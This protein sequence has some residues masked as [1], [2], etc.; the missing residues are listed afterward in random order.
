MEP[1]SIFVGIELQHAWRLF[2][3]AALDSN[4]KL[5]ALRQGRLP[6]VVAY[7][8]EGEAVIAAISA[9]RQPNRGRMQRDEI[10]SALFAPLPGNH[11]VDLRQ[12]EFELLA[13]GL[14]APRT[15]A[16]AATCPAW[17]RRGFRLVQELKDIG[18]AQFSPSEARRQLI[19][20]SPEAVF[21]SLL[22]HPPFPSKSMEG[23]I[24]RQLVLWDNRLPVRDPMVFFEEVTRHKLLRGIMPDQDI[25]PVAKLNALAAAYTAFLAAAH[26]ERVSRYGEPEEGEVYLPSPWKPEKAD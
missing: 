22:G 14:P 8:A 19:E 26:P 11:S 20:T 15:P 23:R 6:E 4:L 12:V 25:L 5:L 7:L 24:Q 2:T 13:R 18:Y 21:T 16:N 3:Y 10:R 17:M 9:P 1:S